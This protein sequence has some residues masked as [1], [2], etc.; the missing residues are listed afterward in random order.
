MKIAYVSAF[1][2]G[3]GGGEGFYA[4]DLAHNA[5]KTN[6]VLMICPSD[7]LYE[8][9][10]ADCKTDCDL[11]IYNLKSEGDPKVR[12]PDFTQK[13]INRLFEFLDEYKPEVVHSHTPIGLGLIVQIWAISRGVPFIYTAHELPTKLLSFNLVAEDGFMHQLMKKSFFDKY[14]LNFYNNCTAVIAINKVT[15]LD[16]RELGYKGKT[17]IIRNA[18]AMEMYQD[19]KP[20]NLA[21][22]EK[23][24]SFIGSIS[25]RKNQAFLVEVVEKLP[26]NYKLWLFGDFLFEDYKKEFPVSEKVVLWG[27][28]DNKKIPEYLEKTHVFVSASKMEVQSLV[29][30][31]ALAS[32]TPVVGLENE[33]VSE[34][35]DDKVGKKLPHEASPKA[36]AAEV[37]KICKMSQ[38][39]YERMCFESKKRVEGF[40]FE[41]I[42][43]ATVALY[44]DS[45]KNKALL[46][47]FKLRFEKKKWI[48]KLGLY[49]MKV[50]S[51]A[52]APVSIS[53]KGIKVKVDEKPLETEKKSKK[54]DVMKNV[55]KSTL[56]FAGGTIIVTLA[57]YLGWRLTHRKKKDKVV[58][59][60]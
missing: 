35:I 60:K 31:E 1:S 6:E 10:L 4:F 11:K 50:K 44:A 41:N 29:I 48:G 45:V 15:E 54:P 8:E 39:D 26:K 58:T 16:I 34:L 57:G 17:E 40:S 38:R 25:L 7:G 19:K 9:G 3:N 43:T 47:E 46:R 18:R 5:A 14:I 22:D 21:A 36:F 56:I 30:L 51:I 23:I 32:G 12:L 27:Q 28:V 2:E 42:V 13:S 20:A 24:L 33:T 53:T 55:P 49:L 37:E 59:S 52:T